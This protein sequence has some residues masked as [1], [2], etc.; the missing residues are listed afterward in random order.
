MS[1]RKK[2][3]VPLEARGETE[4][5][6]ACQVKKHWK[7]ITKE[8][9]IEACF[10]LIGTEVVSFGAREK[11]LLELFFLAPYAWRDCREIPSD[12]SLAFATEVIWSLKEL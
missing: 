11:I 6:D 3:Q 5:Y 2:K 12:L 7:V 8:K 9:W 4:P 1:Q 10:N